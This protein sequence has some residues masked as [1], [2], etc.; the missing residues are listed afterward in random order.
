M[1]ILIKSDQEIIK[2][3]IEIANNFDPSQEHYLL[4]YPHFLN[5]FKNIKIRL[6]S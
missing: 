5:Y 6:P 4:S 1:N 2:Q 3:V